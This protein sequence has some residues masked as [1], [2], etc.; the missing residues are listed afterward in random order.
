MPH[1]FLVSVA[2][3]AVLFA[4]C[5]GAVRSPAEAP[6]PTEASQAAPTGDT[7]SIRGLVVDDEEKPIPAVTVALV[8]LRLE[9]STDAAGA[10][11]FNNITPGSHG[12][13][14]EAVGFQAYAKKVTVVAGEITEFRAVLAPIAIE[15]EARLLI[16]SKTGYVDAGWGLADALVFW[17]LQTC[18]GCQVYFRFDPKPKDAWFEPDW[19]APTVPAVN[20]A[21]YVWLEKNVQNASTGS[22]GTN[23]WS[24]YINHGSVGKAGGEIGNFQDVDKGRANF[25]GGVTSVS[26]QHRVDLWFTFSY[27]DVIPGNH[28]AKPPR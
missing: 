15:P 12:I 6:P 10:F 19:P 7:G 28:T 14:L 3:L 17:R 25:G 1:R 5:S 23:M 24:A 16:F 26:F 22:T 4:G 21:I 8:S 18:S 11:T 9:T 20:A 2:V 13:V 27:G